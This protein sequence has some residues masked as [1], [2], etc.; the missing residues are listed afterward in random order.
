MLDRLEAED[1]WEWRVDWYRG[2]AHLAS[3]MPDA[4]FRAFEEVYR[5]IPGELA[6]KCAMALAAE[7]AGDISTATRWAEVV[8]YTDPGFTAAAMCLARCRLASGD[9]GGAIEAY[10]L[11]PETAGSYVDAQMMIVSVLLGRTIGADDTGVEIADVVRA[12]N[13]V[14]A[15]ALAPEQHARA[16]CEIFETAL[17]VIEGDAVAIDGDAGLPRVLGYPLAEHDLRLALERAYRSLAKFAATIKDR[18]AFVN[19]ANRV[20]P[21]TIV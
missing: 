19:A 2:I 16:S 4:A 18:V 17:T 5:V 6:P 20:R 8:A 11:V 3:R 10:E 7:L 21:W 13:I 1:P 12:A 15:L 9:R 14:D